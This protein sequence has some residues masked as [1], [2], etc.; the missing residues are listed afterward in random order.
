MKKQE[1]RSHIDRTI[2]TMSRLLPDGSIV[3]QVRG[4]QLVFWWEGGRRIAPMIEYRG[5]KY[6][7]A[8]LDP[9]LDNALLPDGPQ[10][11]G[12]VEHLI[13]ELREPLERV[14]GLAVHGSLAVAGTALATWTPEYLPGPVVLNLWGAAGA[15]LELHDLLCA[16]CRRPLHLAEPSLSQVAAL[17]P[18]MSPTLILREPS[19]RALSRLV[20]A[21]GQPGAYFASG[22]RVL[23]MCC[24]VIVFTS[25][26]VTIP[27]L[28]IG[29]RSTGYHL[30]GTTRLLTGTLRQYFQPRL[31]QF[32]LTQHRTI[33]NSRFDIAHVNPE[34]RLVARVLGTVVDGIPALQAKMIEALQQLDR[35]QKSEQFETSVPVLESLLSL[36]HTERSK[37]Y[38]GEIAELGNT[39]LENS[40]EK[41][42]FS[43]KAVGG[44]LRQKLG[45]CVRR[46]GP[47]YELTLDDSVKREI[48]RLADAY[49]ILQPLATCSW[50]QKISACP[51]TGS[52]TQPVEN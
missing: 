12:S 36:C 42:T 33:A 16:L 1:Q 25:K 51:D 49:G 41:S 24:P 32:R 20:A 4:G 11:F 48:H 40:G 28:K 38:V 27:A 2:V 7:P 30:E 35:E 17:P 14:P 21:V 43:P 46:Q 45:L 3:D 13:G 34:A 26:P 23:N 44:I 22:C 6:V 9:D 39:I 19:D 31:L 50:C 47:G 10:D 15:E 8:T 52:G 5:V 37:V 18:G 29:L